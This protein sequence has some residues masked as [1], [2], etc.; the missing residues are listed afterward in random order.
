MPLEDGWYVAPMG[1]EVHPAGE[2]SPPFWSLDKGQV[3]EF[4][5]GYV[6]TK[7]FIVHAS[8]GGLKGALDFGWIEQIN[9]EEKS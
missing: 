9:K 2:S 3:F 5:D 8:A 7:D 1:L 6:W 4:R